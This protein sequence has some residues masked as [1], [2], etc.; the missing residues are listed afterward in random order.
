MFNQKKDCCIII[1]EKGEAVTCHVL[2]TFDIEETNK[3][4]VVY[5][6]GVQNESGGINVFASTYDPGLEKS[7]LGPVETKEEWDVIES[8]LN[9]LQEKARKQFS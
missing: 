8:I 7:S 3:H 2:F 5:T 6:D 4:Y 1:N 9:S